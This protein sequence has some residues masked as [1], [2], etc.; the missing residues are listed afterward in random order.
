MT[1]LTDAMSI[2]LVFF[3]KVTATGTSRKMIG[4]VMKNCF[5]SRM[6]A[7]S[8]RAF[9]IAVAYVINSGA[10]MGFKFASATPCELFIIVPDIV[11]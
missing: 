1:L 2:F 4:V 6:G 9:T 7:M 11:I 10:L 8:D 3:K 5:F